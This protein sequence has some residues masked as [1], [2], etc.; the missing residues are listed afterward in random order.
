[1]YHNVGVLQLFIEIIVDVH[2]D[3]IGKIAMYIFAKNA[4]ICQTD[5]RETDFEKD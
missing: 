3:E 2:L 1:M 5:L 4:S